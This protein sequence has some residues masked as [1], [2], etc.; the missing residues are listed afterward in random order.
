MWNPRIWAFGCSETFGHGLEDCYVK[1]DGFYAPGKEPSKFAYPQLIGD[2]VGKE[3]INLSRPGASNKHIL[4]QIKL[5]QSEIN[6]DDI[7]IIHWTYIER[8][9]VFVN[10]ERD[11]LN[12]TPHWP[13]IMPTDTEKIAKQ[14]YKYIHSDSDAIIVVRWYM[15]YAHLTLKAQGVKSIHCPPL[16]NAQY[17]NNKSLINMKSW[18]EYDF[19]KDPNFESDIS[20]VSKMLRHD[21]IQKDSA[22]DG[23]HSG[24]K[25]HRAFADLILKEF[26]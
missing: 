8:H 2:T 18:H 24:P 26:F 16:M 23:R 5:N 1:K 6:K 25:T 21:D 14:Y 22:I 20:F 11:N 19:V 15:N 10:D 3:V 7:V 9:A 17:N 4:Q 13:D 12:I